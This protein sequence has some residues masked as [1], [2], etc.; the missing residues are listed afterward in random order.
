[1]Q[2]ST[3]IRWVA[4]LTMIVSAWWIINRLAHQA[5]GWVPHLVTHL[6]TAGMGML[7]VSVALR[8]YQRLGH[9]VVRINRIGVRLL[10]M[11]ATL[12]TLA[13]LVEALSAIIE[14]REA[15]IM[16]NGS[17][18]AATIGLLILFIGALIIV[19]A[20]VVG[21]RLPS[22][23]LTLAVLGIAF[24]LFVFIFPLISGLG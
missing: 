8:H 16:H 18:L 7:L 4:L 11:G 19:F 13:Q 15:G 23:E 5:S 17:S 20:A 22:W 14:Y 10:I 9:Q 1:M 2:F 12:F 6:T 21:R 24:V 3:F